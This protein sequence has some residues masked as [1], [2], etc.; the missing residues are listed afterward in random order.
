[1]TKQPDIYMDREWL[2][3]RLKIVILVILSGVVIKIFKERFPAEL[4]S[5]RLVGN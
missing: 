5:G 2:K 1:L 4:I 3:C